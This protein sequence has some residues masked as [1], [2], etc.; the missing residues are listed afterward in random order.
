MR[1]LPVNLSAFM[2]E[3][4]SLEQTMALTDSLT[5]MPIYGIDEIT[6]AARTILIRY[7]P[8]RID[9]NELVEKISVRDVSRRVGKASKLVTIPV[10]YNGEDLSDVAAHLG[11]STA[12]VIRR[13]T[14]NEFQVAF[15]GFAPGFGY[16]VSKGANLNVPRRQSPRVRI[17]AGS[18]ALAG[19]FSSVYPQA[20]PGGWQLIGVTELLMWDINRPEP[21]LVQAGMR[22][23]FVDATK[24]QISY[25]LPTKVSIEKNAEN[26]SADLTVLA[27]GLQVLFQDLG[28]I[29]QSA[30]GISESG[31]MDKSALRS[32]N[33]I[34]G[35]KSDSAVLEITQGGFKAQVHKDLIV[36]VTGAPC[37]IEVI[38][39]E[40][41]QYQVNTYQPIHLAKGDTIKLSR[42][43][44]GVRS[45]F[46]VRGGF[47]IEPILS[48]RSFDT[49]AQVGPAPIKV[50][51]TLTVST[52][53][54]PL[55]VSLNET[56][57][58]DY[59]AE[60]D[61]VVLDV[62]LGPR[63]DWFTKQT[64]GQLTKQLWQVTASSNRIGLRLSSEKPLEREQL[65]ELPSEGTCIGAIQV[66]ANGQPVLF[67][68]D[69]PLTGGYPVIG[70]V[71][72]Y[73]LD[74]A[75]QIPV[76]AKIRFNPLGEFKVLQGSHCAYENE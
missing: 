63:T 26:V 9:V 75:G 36:A 29:G 1:F 34:V 14:E 56:P 42:P 46:A 70:A 67:L 15:S 37:S 31:S 48:S 33:R 60:N 68:N 40:H 4:E 24:S 51:Q 44:K 53:S 12:E 52:N 43:N 71:C 54:S 13:H 61:V 35:N 69:H 45:Y 16:M 8:F 2:V 55:A 23:N 64:V 73:H 59:P 38:T 7:N 47:N 10:H 30:L 28:R 17:P 62:I 18:V 11:I 74:L 66:P 50:G 19:E 21:A 57:A 32:A 39:K 25:S 20:S 3:L 72:E 22:V 27:T 6:P 5:E 41:Q 76:N 49:L 65:Q 58:F